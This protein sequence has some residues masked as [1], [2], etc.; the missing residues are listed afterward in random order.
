[1]SDSDVRV[2]PDYLQQVSAPFADP[3]VRAVTAFCK[4]LSAGTLASNLDALGMHMDSAPSALV[5]K[6]WKAG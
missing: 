4:S 1:M 3:Q 5:A 6:K 2:E